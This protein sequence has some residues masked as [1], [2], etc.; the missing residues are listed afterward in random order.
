MLHI[1]MWCEN[2]SL[3]GRLIYILNQNKLNNYVSHIT[4]SNFPAGSGPRDGGQRFSILEF[5]LFH[6][7]FPGRAGG[8]D[9]DQPE[10][11]TAPCWIHDKAAGTGDRTTKEETKRAF[12]ACPIRWSF[13]LCESENLRMNV[14][15]LVHAR[16]PILFVLCCWQTD[17]LNQ[18][19]ESKKVEVVNVIYTNK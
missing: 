16:V 7:T 2:F 18:T 8:G 1:S 15:M 4:L 6:W 14:K 12:Q 17:I 10:G 11:G 13:I 3:Q 5:G 9:G 19:E